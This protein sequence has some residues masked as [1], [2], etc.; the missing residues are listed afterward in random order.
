MRPTGKRRSPFPSSSA[1]HQFTLWNHRY[2]ASASCG[3]SVYAPAFTGTHSRKDGHWPG[4]VDRSMIHYYMCCLNLEVGSV[5]PLSTMPKSIRT[6]TANFC[7]I[8]T[9]RETRHIGLYFC[10]RHSF[11]DIQEYCLTYQYIPPATCAQQNMIDIIWL[12]LLLCCSQFLAHEL[13]IGHTASSNAHQRWVRGQH[14]QVQD[15]GH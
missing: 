13:Y 12:I 11:N 8:L 5:I 9:L 3:L 7:M 14:F 10:H 15:Q 6:P 4:W 2:E 1:R